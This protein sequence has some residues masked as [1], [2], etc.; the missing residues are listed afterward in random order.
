MTPEDTSGRDDLEGLPAAYA[1]WRESV[2]GQITD[3]LEE[4][5]LMDRIGPA[6]GLRILDVGCGD[7]L[8]ATRLAS[9][10][11]QVTGLDVS[12]R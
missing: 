2:L 9:E 3:A 8:L 11:A 7:G 1:A 12:Q 6:G 10:G 4:R 5:L